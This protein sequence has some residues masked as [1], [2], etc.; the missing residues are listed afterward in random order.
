MS[1]I[2]VQQL[3]HIVTDMSCVDDGGLCLPVASSSL[4]V[5]KCGYPRPVIHQVGLIA[6]PTPTVSQLVG[7]MLHSL[8][9]TLSESLYRSF[10]GLQDVALTSAACRTWISEVDC[11]PCGQTTVHA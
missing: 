5:L 7:S 11:C 8:R 4:V 1:V 3:Q 6:G 9:M 10:A 2:L